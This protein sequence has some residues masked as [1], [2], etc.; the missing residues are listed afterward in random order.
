[1]KITDNLKNKKW[2]EVYFDHAATTYLKPEVV[3]A[4]EPY[5]QTI[6]GNPS[7]LYALGR[8]AKQVIE[9]SRKIVADIFGCLPEEIIFE[10]SGTESDNHALIGAALANKSRG[11][12]IITSAIEHHAVL[13]A[14]A[15]LETQGFEVT[16]LPVDKFGLLKMDILENSIRPDT[17]LVSIMFANNEIGTLQPIREISQLI[18]IINPKTYFHT[19]A[20]QAAGYYE[21]NVDNLGVDLM[22]INGSKIY[23][24]KGTGVLY[25]KKGIS[26]NPLIH[27]GG[28]ESNRRAG[29]ENVAGIVGLAAALAL[30][31][32][33][34]ENESRRLIELRDKLIAGLLKI[35]KTILNGHPTLRLP[36]NVNVTVMDIEGEAML[37]HLDEKGI[38]ASTGSACTSGDLQPSHVIMALGHPYEMAHGSMRFSLGQVNTQKDI[39]YL[40][41]V[42]PEIVAKLRAMS[43]VHLKN[44][45]S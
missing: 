30:A 29:T 42:F 41:E 13:H 24:P 43:P 4:M 14:C 11:K 22:T 19:D 16:Y 39:D 36:N 17:I 5:G 18:K 12:H 9:R 23:G 10:G 26:I 21:L 40:L 34:R 37:L 15:F 7:S 25:V 38:C 3:K 33:D 35:P 44:P 20:C 28:Q 8:Q 31:Q 32:E 1:M 27:G 2:G 6:Y 45:K